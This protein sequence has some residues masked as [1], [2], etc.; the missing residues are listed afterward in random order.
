MRDVPARVR[1]ACRRPPKANGR[2]IGRTQRRCEIP[3][4][5]LWP[6][7][8]SSAMPTSRIDES[9]AFVPIRIAIMTVSDTR[10]ASNDTSGDTLAQRVAEA[11]HV[12]AARILL[13]DDLAK[14]AAQLGV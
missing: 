2:C 5:P 9:R 8:C 3:F 12:L 10:D 1:R 7:T 13:K 11:G 6:A 4:L 14:I